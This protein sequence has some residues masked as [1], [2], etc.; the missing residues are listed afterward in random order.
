MRWV[1][2]IYRALFIFVL[3]GAC[4]GSLLT[5]PSQ[6]M[7]R[8][9]QPDARTK[10]PLKPFPYTGKTV[11]LNSE[12]GKTLLLTTKW[13]KGE[14]VVASMLLNEIKEIEHIKSA[15]PK[16][17]VRMELKVDRNGFPL[18]LEQFYRFLFV[19]LQ[20]ASYA[21]DKLSIPDLGPIP[22]KE[23]RPQHLVDE[24]VI[25]KTHELFTPWA[26]AHRKISWGQ[27]I[28]RGTVLPRQGWLTYGISPLCYNNY[29]AEESFSVRQHL[30]KHSVS[31]F[32]AL[33]EYL[34]DACSGE[35]FDFYRKYAWL[36]PMQQ[37]CFDNLVFFPD[38]ILNQDIS[39][40]QFDNNIEIYGMGYSKKALCAQKMP[41]I[42]EILCSTGADCPADLQIILVN[43][44]LAT[45]DKER[46]PFLKE[47]QTLSHP[48][49]ETRTEI[50][51]CTS[52]MGWPK[53]VQMQLTAHW[54]ALFDNGNSDWLRKDFLPTWYPES[55]KKDKD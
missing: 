2:K 52:A 7:D 53:K 36:T 54:S 8:D 26:R 41:H 44:F 20:R 29:V 35:F 30:V 48:T 27:P 13:A 9:L 14:K 6:S 18:S 22:V 12:D 50:F 17:R 43:K 23:S 10:P 21:H 38:Q 16:D 42:I 5:S 28:G 4:M 45:F 51:C 25:K 33:D 32:S 49:L 19:V 39:E 31:I 34:N 47:S 15:G 40:E 37:A 1:Q 24:T 11:Q 46:A 3:C 55:L